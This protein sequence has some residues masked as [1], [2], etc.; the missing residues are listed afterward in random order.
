MNATLGTNQVFTYTIEDDDDAP[1]V[2]FTST[3]SNAVSWWD[4]SDLLQVLDYF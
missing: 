3:S 2:A 4:D 1:T